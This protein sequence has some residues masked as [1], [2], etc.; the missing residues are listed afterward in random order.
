MV[1][2]EP[3]FKLHALDD[4]RLAFGLAV[5]E[6]LEGAAETFTHQPSPPITTGPLN[7][8]RIDLALNLL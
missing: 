7:P 2:C 3:E 6:V 5:L 1:A 4:F 8:A